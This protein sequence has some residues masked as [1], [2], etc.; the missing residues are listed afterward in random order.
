MPS[1]RVA[2]LIQLQSQGTIL[3][4]KGNF[5]YNLGI[6]K[7]EAVIGSDRAHGFTEK[8][9]VAF[10]EGMITDSGT[11]DLAALAGGDD[12][13]ITLT[14]GNG[15]VIVLGS[16][17]YAADGNGTSE[18]GEIAVRWESKVQAKEITP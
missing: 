7:R 18:E 6:P 5:T 4:A 8:P 2:G 15:K 9:Q 1:Q 11:L 16:A 13:T 17:Y 14:L 12:L 10:I 3:D